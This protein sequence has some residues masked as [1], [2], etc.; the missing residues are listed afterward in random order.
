MTAPEAAD[1]VPITET[2]LPPKPRTERWALPPEELIKRC[3]C[4]VKREFVLTSTQRVLVEAVTGTQEETAEGTKKLSKRAQGKVCG[5]WFVVPDTTSVS[6]V[7]QELC[8]LATMRGG[9][10][11]MSI[12]NHITR[13]PQPSPPPPTIITT[14]TTTNTIGAP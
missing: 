1:A 6:G 9:G 3:I 14:T 8:G 11:C 10:V 4:P 12:H 13:M 5:C 7:M 2:H